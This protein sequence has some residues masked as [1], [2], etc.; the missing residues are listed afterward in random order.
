MELEN[1]KYML[2]RVNLGCGDE[3]LN[4]WINVDNRSNI[5]KD[6]SFDLNKFPYPF[7]NSEVDECLIK[8]TLPQ[9]SDPIKVINEMVRI[10]KPQGKITIIECHATNYSTFTFPIPNTINI[11]ENTFDEK[12]LKLF[13]LEN[14]IKLVNQEFIYTHKWKKFI[15]FKHALKIFLMGLYD[16][17]RFEFK[18][19]KSK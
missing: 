11:T 14:K 1:K 2:K 18:V 19:I 8:N 3:Y 15:P 6:K 5:K 17:I 9:L 7:K 4:G 10:T 12:G 13:E 16:K